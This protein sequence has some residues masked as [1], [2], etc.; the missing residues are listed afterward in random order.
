M[1]LETLRVRQPSPEMLSACPA[2]NS[3]DTFRAQPAR[4][5]AKKVLRV[6]SLKGSASSESSK[7][8]HQRGTQ[9]PRGFT[10]RTGASQQAAAFEENVSEMSRT[11]ANK[12]LPLGLHDGELDRSN[13]ASLPSQTSLT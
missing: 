5:W 9:L 10:R 13:F 2:I 4:R 7:Q 6:H 8:L 3:V 11:A 1:V 12:L